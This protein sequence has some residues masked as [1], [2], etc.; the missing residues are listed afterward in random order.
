M[1]VIDLACGESVLISG[2]YPVDCPPSLWTGSY[3][4]GGGYPQTAAS[5]HTP[6]PALGLMGVTLNQTGFVTHSLYI[7]AWPRW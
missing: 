5:F 6:L 4:G 1:E 2:H 3:D 7:G